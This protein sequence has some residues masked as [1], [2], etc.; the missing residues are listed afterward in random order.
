MFDMFMESVGDFIKIKSIRI[1]SLQ[2]FSFCLGC[3]IEPNNK[4]FTYTDGY[5]AIE[6]DSAAYYLRYLSN[7]EQ[8]KYSND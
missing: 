1:L 6:W 2:K 8:V 4:E 7:R 3:S 5:I